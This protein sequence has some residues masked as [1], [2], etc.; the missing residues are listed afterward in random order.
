[1]KKI[2]LD[3][4]K[5]LF[6]NHYGIKFIDGMKLMDYYFQEIEE[7]FVKINNLDDENEVLASIID[8]NDYFGD[9][10]IYLH[11]YA[12]YEADEIFVLKASEIHNFID[13]STTT[14]LFDDPLFVDFK[15]NKG[16]FLTFEFEPDN[17]PAYY[18][19]D[20]NDIK[21]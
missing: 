16:F 11:I 12:S 21:M 4:F 2:T 7:H 18:F 20:L 9:A 10:D 8:F 1:M 6:R 19:L 14:I 3:D 17:P 5:K 15:N 13:S